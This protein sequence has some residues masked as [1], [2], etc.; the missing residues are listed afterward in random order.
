MSPSAGREQARRAVVDEV[1]LV[2]RLE[3]EREPLVAERREDGLELALG[4]RPQ[5]VAPERRLSPRP[6]PRSSPRAQV[7]AE[8][9]TDGL[10]GAVDVLVGVRERDEHRLELRRRDVDAALEQ[11]AEE[12]AVALGVA[13]LRV[14]E[15]AH[16]AVGLKSV[17]IAPTRCTRPNA[18]EP[19]LE[20][21]AACAR[22]RSYTAASRSR[23]STARPAAVASGLPQSVPGLVDRPA[24]REPVHHVGAAAER[25]ERQAAADDL[26]EDRQVRRDAVAA[27]ARRRARRGSR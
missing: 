5:R 10:H 3:P 9:L 25:R 12:R 2:D 8:E 6:R 14:L 16:A 27:P 24:R 4:L 13:G 7:A 22:A 26:A 18:R 21:R 11:V 1:A 17:S 19:G 15:V 20:P 23:R